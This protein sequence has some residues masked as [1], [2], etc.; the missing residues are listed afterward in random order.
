MAASAM[1]CLL[2]GIDEGFNLTAQEPLWITSGFNSLA[3]KEQCQSCME[4]NKFRIALLKH[5][6]FVHSKVA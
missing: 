5:L 1:W 4:L 3:P 6:R 2:M